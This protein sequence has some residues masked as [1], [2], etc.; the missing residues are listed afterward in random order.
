MATY[1]CEVEGSASDVDWHTWV[2]GCRTDDQG[3]YLVGA[4]RRLVGEALRI[5]EAEEWGNAIEVYLEALHERGIGCEGDPRR[6]PRSVDDDEM[7]GTES[8]DEM[9]VADAREGKE[10]GA[11]TRVRASDGEAEV[12]ASDV[13]EA[14]H[15]GESSAEA[16]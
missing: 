10:S 13:A 8:V 6:E 3:W 2:A 1:A 16:G 7:V 12:K 9:A 11:Q 5:G 14:D 15:H 4:G